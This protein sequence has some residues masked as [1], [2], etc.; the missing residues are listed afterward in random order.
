MWSL[1]VRYCGWLLVVTSIQNLIGSQKFQNQNV[2]RAILSNSDFWSSSLPSQKW[3]NTR[4]GLIQIWT[5]NTQK[6]IIRIQ[7]YLNQNAY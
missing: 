5:Q 6:K 4:F 2:F 3:D 1:S 7:K